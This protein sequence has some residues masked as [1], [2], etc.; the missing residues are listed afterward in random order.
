MNMYSAT[1]ST[2]IEVKHEIINKPLDYAYAF[3]KSFGVKLRV[4]KLS[5]GD[6]VEKREFDDDYDESR[7]SVD[8]A[9]GIVKRVV[10]G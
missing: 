5:R 10:V 2:A 4:A 9:D 1:I 8:V 3:A 6:N 7:V